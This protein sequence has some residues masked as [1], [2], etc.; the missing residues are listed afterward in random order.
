VHSPVRVGVLD[1]PAASPTV[2]GG[3]CLPG[4]RR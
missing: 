2:L 3:R 1:L 4:V